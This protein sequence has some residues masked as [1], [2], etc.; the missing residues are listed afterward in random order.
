MT[1]HRFLEFFCIIFCYFWSCFWLWAKKVRHAF[2]IGFYNTDPG[3]GLS[4]ST[5][6]SIKIQSKI[7]VRRR[8]GPGGQ[9]VAFLTHFW[10]LKAPKM[11]SKIDTKTMRNFSWKKT[12]KSEP[13][14]KVRLPSPG[15]AKPALLRF[16]SQQRELS[17]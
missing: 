17:Y 4:K 2:R 5:C 15:Y 11:R 14:A 1:F 16:R 9:K 6:K 7:V 10:S 13:R 3:S 8:M 12:E